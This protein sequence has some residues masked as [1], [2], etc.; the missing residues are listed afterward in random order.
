MQTQQEDTI[1][2][3]F[4][5]NGKYSAASAYKAQFLGSTYAPHYKTI[6][7]CWAPPK[8]KFFAWLILQNRVW[9]ADR[10]ARRGWPHSPICP[11]CRIQQETTHHL[12]AQCRYTKRI[13]SLVAIWTSQP[14][15]QPSEWPPTETA[16]QWW[17]NM[18]TRTEA[19]WKGTCS[20]ALLIIW[21]IWKER[22]RRIFNHQEMAAPSLLAK[23]KEEAGTWILAGAKALATFSSRE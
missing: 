19:T 21:E 3:K 14:S 9:T 23:I 13:W 8:C 20:M 17:M 5:S 10:L 2:W 4:T 11:L 1:Q 16:L 15:I 18:T 6:W 7:H 12:V 22:N